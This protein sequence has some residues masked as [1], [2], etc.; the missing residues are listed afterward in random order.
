MLKICRPRGRRTAGGVCFLACQEGV[1]RLHKVA[2]T[3]VC[4]EHT[5]QVLHPAGLKASGIAAAP[6]AAGSIT[7]TQLSSTVLEHAPCQCPASA[8]C[9]E[10]QP[11]T[12]CTPTGAR[13]LSCHSARPACLQQPQAS[14]FIPSIAKTQLNNKHTMPEKILQLHYHQLCLKQPGHSEEYSTDNKP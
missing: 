1:A 6:M 14:C 12:L 7:S 5:P 4:A 11:H 8:H 10:Q 2:L 13:N 3:H 9:Q